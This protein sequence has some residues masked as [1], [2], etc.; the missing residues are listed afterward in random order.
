M[1]IIAI[2]TRGHS[3]VKYEYLGMIL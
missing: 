2:I 3:Q 1:L